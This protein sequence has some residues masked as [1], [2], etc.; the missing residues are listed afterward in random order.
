VA[1]GYVWVSAGCSK[2]CLDIC[3]E[4]SADPALMYFEVLPTLEEG[5]TREQLVGSSRSGRWN[6]C[7][8]AFLASQRLGE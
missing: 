8:L 2:D 3:L 7:L 4:K 5:T 6:L 1:L